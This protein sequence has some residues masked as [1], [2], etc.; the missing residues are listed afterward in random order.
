MA[1]ILFG[2][3]MSNSKIET[4]NMTST[5]SIETYNT[6]CNHVFDYM[7][8]FSSNDPVVL[9]NFTLKRDHISRVIGYTEVLTRDLG[10]D[11]NLML[12]AQLTAILHDIGRFEQFSQF[13]TFNDSLSFD[14]A[15][16]AIQLIDDNKWL[17][18]LPKEMQEW[19]KK[20]VLYHNKIVIPK[21]EDKNVELLSKIIRDADKI[22]IL[23]IAAKEFALTN[24]KKNHSFSLELA[25]KPSFTKNVAKAVIDGR[26]ADKKDLQNT[27]DFKLML[28]SFVFDVNFKKTFAII[29]QRQYL[30]QLFDTLPKSDDI[31]EAFR[32]T[33]IHI[34]NQLI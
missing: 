28:M 34:E 17:E 3:L 29:N 9:Q 21:G 24:N 11:D 16:K 2:L 25:N 13:K 32:I 26:I 19:I 33:K 23:D 5:I 27:N 14:H 6:I 8:N 18:E 30:K 10:V 22:D 1:L 7:L 31:F 20:A 4:D 12:A 15:E